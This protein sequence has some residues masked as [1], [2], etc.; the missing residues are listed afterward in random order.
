MLLKIRA[1]STRNIFGEPLIVSGTRTEPPELSAISSDA[2]RLSWHSSA[3]ADDAA[4]QDSAK[5]DVKM[6]HARNLGSWIRNV[7]FFPPNS[8]AVQ[9]ASV[10]Q[11]GQVCPPASQKRCSMP[12]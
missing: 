4:I 6:A 7:I 9:F 12:S 2:I 3:S 10:R 8:I 11:S 1:V 5:S